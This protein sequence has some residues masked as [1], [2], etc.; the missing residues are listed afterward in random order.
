MIRKM[1]LGLHKFMFVGI[2]FVFSLCNLSLF[3]K[4][5]CFM[6]DSI[7]IGFEQNNT[8]SFSS[9]NL[10]D[11]YKLLP[12]S[13][14]NKLESK[15]LSPSNTYFIEDINVSNRY[16]LVMKSNN[17]NELSH[18]G[19]NI[20]S[21]ELIESNYCKVIEYI[22]R[23]LLTYLLLQTDAEIKQRM[24]NNNIELRLNGNLLNTKELIASYLVFDEYTHFNLNN[25]SKQFI[26]IWKLNSSNLI[27]M[28]FTNN[29]IFIAG[30]QKDEIE[31]EILRDLK[32]S[33]SGVEIHK[34]IRN[35]DDQ[36]NCDRIYLNSGITYNDSPNITSDSYFYSH[37]SITPV[38]DT[39]NHKESLNNLLLNLVPTH[40]NFQIRHKLYG[41]SEENY[42]I[43]I[44]DFFNHFSKD[45]DIFI[46]WGSNEKENLSASIFIYNVLFNYTHLL[47]VNTN[48]VNFS[49]YHGNINGTLYTFIRNDNLK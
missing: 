12:E 14:K 16:G 17:Y 44:N 23:E 24:N 33:N 39:L 8:L 11:L 48:M 6:K 13:T 46:G 41:N 3:A 19:L 29:Y 43:N 7:E 25:D 21:S 49:N 31:N 42:T 1:I 4:E 47:V 22:E 15:A 38:F 36:V 10:H 30:K 27:T 2:F 35:L 9:N 26:A 28:K 32:Y 45:H 5:V 20:F 37:D 18:I 40:I 34:Q